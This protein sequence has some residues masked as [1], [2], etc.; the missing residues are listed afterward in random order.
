M[1]MR[2][3]N[4][5]QDNVTQQLKSAIAE[6]LPESLAN[7]EFDTSL[8]YNYLVDCG[9]ISI[10]PPLEEPPMM[11]LLTLDSLRVPSN[12]GIFSS[13]LENWLSLFQKLFLLE[14]VWLV[15]IL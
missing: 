11:Q 8:I 9:F 5:L 15:T 6:N 12:R 13:I 3:R 10:T 14:W 7:G 1:E 2:K 4:D